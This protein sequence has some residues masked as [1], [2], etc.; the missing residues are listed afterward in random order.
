VP[1]QHKVSFTGRARR[2]VA[3]VTHKMFRA[4]L[5]LKK[6]V[7]FRNFSK[8][9]PRKICFEKFAL[10]CGT[11]ALRFALCAYTAQG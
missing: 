2:E 3:C 1:T 5:T 9:M 10:K 6:V 7:L 11:D 8:K 4:G